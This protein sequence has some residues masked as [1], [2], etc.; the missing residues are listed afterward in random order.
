VRLTRLPGGFAAVAR[1]AGQLSS[2]NLLPSE[3]L[4]FGGYYSVR[5][6]EER[7]ANVD[8]G[9]LTTLELRSP[10]ASLLAVVT[11]GS[12]R[13]GDE[14]QWLLFWDYAHGGSVNRL[15]GE[16]RHVALSSIGPGFRWSLGDR[17]S[18]RFDYGFQ[19][20]DS[21]MGLGLGDSRMHVGAILAY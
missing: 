2:E 4:G 15:P 19:L 8:R 14:F 5:G 3:Q 21:G 18:M 10:A 17:F 12:G 20:R 13:G 9:V 1:A 7:E 6:Y 11:P 16:A